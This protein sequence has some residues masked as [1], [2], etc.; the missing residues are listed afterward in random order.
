M[1]SKEKINNKLLQ[2]DAKKKKNIDN[3]DDIGIFDDPSNLLNGG[4]GWV[5]RNQTHSN[6]LNN[7][8]TSGGDNHISYSLKDI[9][10]RYKKES[11]YINNLFGSTIIKGIII[12]IIPSD[13]GNLEY[14]EKTGKKFMEEN[15]LILGDKEYNI[16][17]VFKEEEYRV[18]TNRIANTVH[19]MDRYEF[20]KDSIIHKMEEPVQVPDYLMDHLVFHSNNSKSVV[21]SVGDKVVDSEKKEVLISPL[22]FG[23]TSQAYKAEPITGFRKNYL[24]R[25]YKKEAKFFTI[26]YKEDEESMCS[27]KEMKKH[28]EW[29][30]EYGNNLNVKNVHMCRSCKKK[31][32]SGCCEEYSQTNKT[33]WKMVIGW[34]KC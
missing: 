30:D 3:N 11:R 10:E 19:I 34:S 4:V 31:W 2:K 14:K 5:S 24:E 18:K 8:S 27:W 1:P 23:L 32:K 16:F 6:E 26:Y 29:K 13:D 12:K 22:G 17:L 33:T 20:N 15:T 9:K 25:A 7:G 28:P 21:S